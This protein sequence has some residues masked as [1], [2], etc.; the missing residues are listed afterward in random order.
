MDAE[1]EARFQRIEALL[2]ASAAYGE[3]MELRFNRRMDRAEARAAKFEARMDKGE[4]RMDK[5]DHRLEATRK[6]VEAGMK[7]MVR[8]NARID[9]IGKSQKLILKLLQGGGNG[10]GKLGAH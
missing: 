9:E 6:L 1:V 10:H 8:M 5:F 4:A 3:K 7:M 2:S